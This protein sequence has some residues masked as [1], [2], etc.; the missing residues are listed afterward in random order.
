MMITNRRVA[1]ILMPM[2]AVITIMMTRRMKRVVKLFFNVH[3]IDWSAEHQ[4]S[5]L[6]GGGLYN[7]VAIIPLSWLGVS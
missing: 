4:R 1:K 6:E 5:L 7:I 2:R 3:G